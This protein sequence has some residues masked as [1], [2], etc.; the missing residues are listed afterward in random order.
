MALLKWGSGMPKIWLSS[1]KPSF[2][3]LLR[4]SHSS[5]LCSFRC[6]FNSSQ[7]RLCLVVRLDSTCRITTVGPET[8]KI[9]SME[10]PNLLPATA[11]PPIATARGILSSRRSSDGEP[12]MDSNMMTYCR[13]GNAIMIRSMRCQGD[14]KCFQRFSAA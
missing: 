5:L 11:L 1:A 13:K 8:G 6:V 9:D 7:V 2:D 3:I 10:A 14:L 12:L 4:S